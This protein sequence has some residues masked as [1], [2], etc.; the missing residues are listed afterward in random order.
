VHGSKGAR[1]QRVCVKHPP[2]KTSHH[3]GAQHR[4]SQCRGVD[5]NEGG[6]LRQPKTLTVCDLRAA[7]IRTARHSERDCKKAEQDKPRISEIRIASK[8]VSQSIINTTRPPTSRSGLWIGSRRRQGNNDIKLP[9][10]HTSAACQPRIR[11][12]ESCPGRQKCVGLLYTR[13]LPVSVPL[14]TTPQTPGVNL[15]WHAEARTRLN[16][17]GSPA[18]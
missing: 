18:Y 3:L 12:V 8:T 15:R 5:R 1:S 10:H 4:H 11:A 13:A 7:V 16:N 2:K 6:D 17:F 9:P 14:N